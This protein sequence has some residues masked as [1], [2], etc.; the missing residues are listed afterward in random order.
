MD[1][2]LSRE[3]DAQTFAR[4]FVARSV[5]VINIKLSLLLFWVFPDATSS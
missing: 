5:V 3:N 2:L 4:V 1:Y